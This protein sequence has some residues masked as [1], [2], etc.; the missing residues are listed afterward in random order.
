MTLKEMDD[1]GEEAITGKIVFLAVFITLSALFIS[2][3]Y[4]II[5]DNSGGNW[6]TNS[7]YQVVGN[8][9]YTALLPTEGYQ[10]SDDNV[11]SHITPVTTEPDGEVM[12]FDP[13]DISDDDAV[14]VSIVRDNDLFNPTV[15][16]ES[17]LTYRDFFFI[18]CD[19]GGWLGMYNP[20]YDYITLSQVYSDQLPG[21]NVSMSSISLGDRDYTL[22]VTTPGDGADFKSYVEQNEYVL[23][24]VLTTEDIEPSGSMWAIIGQVLTMDLP[25]TYWLVD[26]ILFTVGWTIIGIVVIEVWARLWPL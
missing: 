5:A 8:I 2:Q 19:F 26:A 6:T 15:G 20:H 23:N 1:S 12:R 17:I 18:K 4:Y 21:L 22:M 13:D 3:S 9:T 14:R 16:G 7:G 25:N 24:V 10:I 11:S